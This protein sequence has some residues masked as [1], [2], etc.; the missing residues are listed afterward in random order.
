MQTH[1]VHCAVGVNPVTTIHKTYHGGQFQA[2]IPN[3]TKPQ[4]PRRTRL[5]N[6]PTCIP[7]CENFE[8][9]Q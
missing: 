4:I 9:E 8:Y 1:N 2:I 3:S 5:V 6:E 7:I